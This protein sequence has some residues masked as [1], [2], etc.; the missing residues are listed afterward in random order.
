MTTAYTSRYYGIVRLR[1]GS[2]FAPQDRLDILAFGSRADRDAWVAYQSLWRLDQ[3][4][5]IRYL[6]TFGERRHT[7]TGAEAISAITELMGDYDPAAL[8]HL[9]TWPSTAQEMEEL[10]AIE[11]LGLLTPAR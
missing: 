6:L 11:K 2:G 3:P 9:P 5:P 7:A 10:S 4:E 1:P 8:T